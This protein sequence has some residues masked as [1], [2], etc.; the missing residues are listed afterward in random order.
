MNT[1]ITKKDLHPREVS[2]IRY[3][4]LGYSTVE[5]ATLLDLKPPTVDT[6]R[7][8]AMKALGVSKAA[9]VTRMALLLKI[10]NLKDSL[11]AEEQK[12]LSSAPP[13]PSKK[14]AKTVKKK[15]KKAKKK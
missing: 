13:V 5:I 9:L 1:S 10:S 12:K 4:S 7:T 8:S 2:V 11:T 15:T 3:I 14:K 6:Y